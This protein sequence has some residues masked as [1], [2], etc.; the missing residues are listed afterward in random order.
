M[1]RLAHSQSKSGTKASSLMKRSHSPYNTILKQSFMDV[2]PPSYNQ[3]PEL[4]KR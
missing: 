2:V 1:P 4:A 3:M